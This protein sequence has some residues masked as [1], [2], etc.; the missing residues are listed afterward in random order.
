MP[1]PHGKP[2]N[3]QLFLHQ[4]GLRQVSPD[5]ERLTKTTPGEVYH[6]VRRMTKTTFVKTPV[7]HLYR[8]EP[9][10]IYYA[11]L[12]ING[13]NKWI[14]LKTK[15]FSVAKLELL[16]V[17]KSHY[18]L[19]DAILDVR[20]GKV[21]I[22]GLATI[23]LQGVA[24]NGGIKKVT[25]DYR[26]KMVRYLFRS[27]P[28][29]PSRTPGR[30]TETECLEWA[31]RY[32]A[33][34]SAILFNN[35]LD[36]LRHIFE[37]AIGRGLI[38]RNPAARIEKAR[39]LQK[40][41]E[42]PSREGF[43]AIVAE[44]RNAG[45]G[46]SAGNGDLVEF[47]AYSGLRATE[48]AN[49]RW[50]DLDFDRG[51]I[52]VAPGKNGQSRF[53]PILEPM[54]NLLA[55]IQQDPRWFRSERRRKAGCL[56]SVVECEKAL[57]SACAKIGT[58]RLTRH[59]LRHLFATRCIESGVDIPTVSRWLGHKDGGGLCMRTY[60]HLRDLHSQEMAAKVTF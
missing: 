6:G 28:E 14:S 48:A 17:L 30:L 56:L 27:W 29:L 57:T 36:T 38:A 34:Y 26:V 60:G 51:R 15:V 43:H 54:R 25:K 8:R 12:F 16:D 2:I 10:G 35:T 45:S 46:Y 55:R 50:Q 21:T 40:K 37:V 23:Y 22:E 32:Q 47:L 4:A 7:Q 44:I 9:L 11:R 19:H 39:I 24:L 18:S 20:T 42:L 49:I 59:D 13:R 52:Y 58:Y 41:L 3:S 5:T 53:V 31:A 33:K 1:L